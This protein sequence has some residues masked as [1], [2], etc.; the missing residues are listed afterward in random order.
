M[1]KKLLLISAGLF[2]LTTGVHAAED[3]SHS[4]LTAQSRAIITDYAAMR[5]AGETY[6]AHQKYDAKLRVE[7]DPWVADGLGGDEAFIEKR[8]EAEPEKYDSVE[9]YVNVMH[10]IMADGDLAAIKSH[11]FTNSKDQGRVFVDIW[12]LDDGKIVEHWDVIQPIET[13]SVNAA[14]VGCGVGTT[15]ETARQ[16]GDTVHNPACGNP[17]PGADAPANR[18]RILDYMEMG[19]QPGKLVQA[20]NT[21]V[22]PDFV[23]HAVRIPPGRQGLIDY[24]EPK[25]AARR[26]DNQRSEVARVMADGDMVLVHRRVWSDSD[27][28]G[29]AFVD[30]FRMKDGMIIDHWD[31]VQPIPEFSVSGRSMAGGPDTPLEP[32]RR[33]GGPGDH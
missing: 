7:H 30:L 27:P 33:R 29:T 1:T 21:Y 6:E 22:A 13:S 16:A 26:A 8:R 3:E 11:V 19:T 12:R 9:H 20:V 17:Q 25:M 24:L 28:R 2:T 4:M 23:Q 15:Y 32:G 5:A 14:P 18:K 31:L 10:T